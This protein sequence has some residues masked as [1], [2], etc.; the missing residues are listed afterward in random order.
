MLNKLIAI[1]DN[2]NIIYVCFYKVLEFGTGGLRGVIGVSINR[3]NIY[4]IA[5]TTQGYF[6]YINRH[7]QRPSV[8]IVYDSKIKS[9]LFARVAVG[10]LV[11]NRLEYIFIRN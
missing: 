6:D 4:T 10:V 1:K 11:A 9:D 8:A 3:M 7:F 5:K 2:E